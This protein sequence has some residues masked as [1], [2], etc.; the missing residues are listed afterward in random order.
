MAERATLSVVNV[1]VSVGCAGIGG[2]PADATRL[3]YPGNC[4]N[5]AEYELQ[6][7]DG[8]AG[9]NTLTDTD[10]SADEQNACIDGHNTCSNSCL[11]TDP[12]VVTA[13]APDFSSDTEMIDC[14]IGDSCSDG[15]LSWTEYGEQVTGQNSCGTSCWDDVSGYYYSGYSSEYYWWCSTGG[16]GD[17]EVLNAQ[18]RNR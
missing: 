12:S 13:P 17:E 6:F 4:D 16:G 7:W 10:E 15:Y 11:Y 1:P 5:P 2:C 9:P 8:S 3:V 18:H 14:Q